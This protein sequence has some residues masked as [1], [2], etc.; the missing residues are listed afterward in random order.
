MIVGANPGTTLDPASPS[1]T[2]NPPAQAIYGGLFDPNPTNNGFSPDLAT[3][4][5]YSNGYRTLTI[6]LRSGVKFQDGTAFN[7]SAVKF[8]LIRDAAPTSTSAGYL[9]DVSSITTPNA[10]TVVLHLSSPN[11]SLA[12]II[13]IS[14]IDLIASPTAVTNAGQNYGLTAVGAG[15]YKF[16]SLVPNT[17]MILQTWPGYWDARHRYLNQVEF[18]TT[19][20][21]LQVTYQAL[22]SNSIQIETSSGVSIPPSVLQEAAS[23]PGV[24]VNYGVGGPVAFLPLNTKTAPFNNPLAREALDYCLNREALAQSTFQG[25][26]TPEYVLSSTTEDFYPGQK[27]AKAMM[28]YPYDPAKGAAIVQQL[29]G[30]SFGLIGGS[31]TQQE[32]FTEA[33]AQGFT[34]CGMKVQVSF[35]SPA[36]QNG[37]LLSGAFNAE[38]SAAGG[39]APPILAVAPFSQPGTGFDQDTLNNPTIT[40]LLAASELAAKPAAV[41]GI[42]NRIYTLENKLAVNIPILSAPSVAISNS[43]LRNVQQFSSA[44]LLQHAYYA[45]NVPGAS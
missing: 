34:N 28:P 16:E 20:T 13:A 38:V 44:V 2:Q 39:V 24:K 21:D 31:K 3:G 6:S 8:N 22:L 19:S 1:F 12:S 17:E 30:M 40:R 18:L 9:Q 36:P 32:T 35:E 33:V 37:S 41:Q 7:S 4:Y 25:H 27:A 45:C 26:A 29:G 14:A 11:T 15:P 23:N 5:T 10:T 42:W 43:C